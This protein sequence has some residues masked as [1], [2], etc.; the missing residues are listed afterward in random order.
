MDEHG[1]LQQSLTYLAAAV[2]SVPIARKLGLG[3]VLGYL[4]AG[5]LIGPFVFKLV[6]SDQSEVLHFAE[7]GVVMMLFLV[8]L[9]LRPSRLWEMRVSILGLGGLQVLLS[10]LAIALVCN[11]LGLPIKSS[12]AVGMI[13]SLSS[14]AIVLQSLAERG[15][16]KTSPGESAFS[17]LL[18]QDIAVIPLLAVLPFLAV[19][20]AQ[21]VA[22]THAG[23]ALPPAQQ[24]LYLLL[25][26]VGMVLGARFAARPAFRFIAEAKLPEVF[27]AAALLLVIALAYL[28]Q[29]VGVSPALGAFL[30]GVVLAESEFR[31]ELESNI[32]PFK[33]LLLGLFFITVGATMDLG[34]FAQEWRSIV[35]LTTVLLLVKFGVLYGLGRVFK[36]QSMNNLLF[37]VALCQSGEFAFVLF[38]TARSYG[39]LE[40]ELIDLLTLVVASSMIM[41]PLLMIAYGRYSEKW[42]E[43]NAGGARTQTMESQE[44]PVIVAGYGRFGQIVGRL[45]HANGFGVTL[46]DHDA[47]RIEMTRMYGYKVYYG[48]ASR[49][50]LLHTAGAEDAKILVVAVEDRDQVTKIVTEATKHFPHLKIMARAFDRHHQYQL[51]K[52]G[53]QIIRREMFSSALELGVEALKAMGHRSFQ[54]H[55]AGQVFRAHDEQMLNE[56][57]EMWHQDHENYIVQARERREE[58]RK[59]MSADDRDADALRDAAWERPDT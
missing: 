54:A 55:R 33:G 26:V 24:A 10:T 49:M 38:T 36:M 14:T 25:I 22:D 1:L 17:V 18:F 9:E 41:T 29:L 8:G 11:L 44:N 30:G 20:D 53:C 47:G 56:M 27:T 21:T 37:A 13:L 23:A 40:G 15:L 6:G 19:A 50:D 51:M 34:L 16:L 58:L 46:L 57:F 59:L 4:I 7:F 52:L 32:E 42:S 39:V 3:S 43:R 28:M 45:L 48:D 2:L 31:H 12:L 35:L 5:V